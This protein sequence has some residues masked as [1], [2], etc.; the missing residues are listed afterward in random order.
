ME[1]APSTTATVE[2]ASATSSSMET[3]TTTASSV[4]ASATLRECRLR[5][6]HQCHQRDK[7]KYEFNAGGLLHLCTL[8]RTPG[9]GDSSAKIPG[10]FTPNLIAAARLWLQISNVMYQRPLPL[11]APPHEFS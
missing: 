8:H 1:S 7:C 4:S 2:A 6:T 11:S 3:A 10:D 9:A 5:S